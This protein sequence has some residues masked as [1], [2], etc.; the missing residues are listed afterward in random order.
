MAESGTSPT[1]VAA[2][3]GTGNAPGLG[4]A[5]TLDLNTGQASYAVPIPLPEGVAGR[6]PQLKLEYRQGRG[7]GPFGMGWDLPLRSID[8][9]LDFGVPGEGV[10]ERFT[11]GGT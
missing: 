5:F 11:D 1:A 3:A 4:E 7:N 9:R 10:V 8:R 2:P 6:Q